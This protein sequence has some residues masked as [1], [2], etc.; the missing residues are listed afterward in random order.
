MPACASRLVLSS[1]DHAS[2]FIGKENI[3]L[4]QPFEAIEAE[5]SV[6]NADLQI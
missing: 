1:P 6:I 4:T 5:S 3:V 2:V